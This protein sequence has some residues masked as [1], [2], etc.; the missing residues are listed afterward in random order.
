MNK[1]DFDNNVEHLLK[2]A[3]NTLITKNGRY[4]NEDKLHNFKRGAEISGM[5][6]AQTCWGYVTKHLTA[7]SDMINNENYIDEDDL[8]EK[9]QDSINY[10]IFEYCLIK[11][12]NSKCEEST[13]VY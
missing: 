4:A 12:R 2:E 3:H 6:P 8:L 9:C 5:S 10:I 13:E 7:L 1:Q 11:E